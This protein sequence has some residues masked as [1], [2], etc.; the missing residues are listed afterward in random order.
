MYYIESGFV[1]SQ[2]IEQQQ[3]KKRRLNSIPSIIFLRK[4]KTHIQKKTSIAA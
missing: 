1:I 4:Q 2:L 3:H